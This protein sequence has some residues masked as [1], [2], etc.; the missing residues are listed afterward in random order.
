MIFY[1]T[2]A[3]AF[4][5]QKN[6][7]S[8]KNERK[9]VFFFFNFHSATEFRGRHCSSECIDYVRYTIFSDGKW[10]G[11]MYKCIDMIFYV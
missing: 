11:C 8:G 9:T 6:Y 10:V 5:V 2:A 4:H 1:V 7:S 3:A